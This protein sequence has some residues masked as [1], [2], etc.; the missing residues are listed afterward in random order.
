[1]DKS[2]I[3][4]EILDTI[5]NNDMKTF[6]KECIK[7]IPDY[8]W[9]VGASSTGKYHPSYALGDLGLARHT[10]ALVRFLNHTFA[11]ESLNKFTSRERDILRVAGMMH[12]SRKSGSQT[13]YENDKYTKFNH[14]LLAAEVIRLMEEKH[15]I[16]DEEV[17]MIA[18][19]IESHMG[20]W[21]TDKRSDVVLP[22]P[23]TRF[24]KLLHWAD[25]LASRK[26]IEIKFDN[27]PNAFLE[28]Q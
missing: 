9:D 13:D 14:P 27:N 12:D 23:E 22:K 4:S 15:I 16:P 25:Y 26:D 28:I 8:F 2:L 1:M 5:E 24:Q 7:T 3:F 21:N 19:I 11:I 10:C 17:E 6:A 20:Q 18:S